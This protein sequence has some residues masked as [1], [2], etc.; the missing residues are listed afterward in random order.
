MAFT[1]A[2]AD[3][4]GRYDLLSEAV[5]R[6]IEHSKARRPATIVTLGDYVDRGPKSRQV[7]ERLMEWGSPDLKLICLK[8]NHED[9]M[10]QACRR[11]A[12]LEW[13][14]QNGGGTTLISYGQHDGDVANVHAVPVEHLRWMDTLPLMHVDK[15]RI[16]VHA[17]VEPDVPLEKQAQQ[18]D[19]HG[20][21]SVLWKRYR[22]DDPRGHGDR[23]VVH[24]HHPF[25]D[26]PKVMIGRTNLDTFAFRTGRLVVGVFDDDIPGG[27]VEFLEVRAGAA[28]A[29]RMAG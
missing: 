2:I 25:K 18:T 28:E 24:G 11:P 26:G 16:Y 27:A 14:I 7:I 23:H 20:N 6:I 12:Q 9:I 5:V 8:G 17:G 22:D 10:W 3:L 13:W 4:H 19:M 15:H 1:Y 29:R 21:L